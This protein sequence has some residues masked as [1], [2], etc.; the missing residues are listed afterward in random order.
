[1][2]SA[3]RLFLGSI[4]ATS[5]LLFACNTAGLKDSQDPAVPTGSSSGDPTP[6]EEGGASEDGGR[7]PPPELEG[8]ALPMS[9]NVSVQ[10]QPS[11]FGVAILNAIKGA[12]K[13][14]H[15]T[16]YLL[17]NDQ[18]INALGT[19]KNAGVD[20]KVVLNQSF[21][22]NAGNNQ[23]AYNALKAKGVNVRWAPS[24]Y[25]YTH[26]KTVII[27]GTSLLVM[28]M[29]LTE[30]S[31]K[32]NREF[33]ATDT[34]PQD[35]ADAE[36]IFDADYNDVTVVLNG[37]LVLSPQATSKLDARVRL[38]ALIDSAKKSVD[39]E[40]QS[41]SDKEITDSIV[42]AKKAGIACRVVL[43][44]DIGAPTPSEAEA[45][46]KLKGASI[47]V[48]DVQDPYIHAKAIVVDGNKAFVGSQ[49]FTPTALFN[50]REMGLITD[51]TATVSKLS[52]IIGQDFAA[53]TPR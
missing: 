5:A 50:N 1:M 32:D 43:A 13:S 52:Q 35:V 11:D 27:D 7:T 14:V 42:N 38:K 41:L 21:P 51:S 28:T 12:K 3:V 48:V 19:L 34:D 9:T 33:I 6:E 25:T 24:A 17:T 20:V 49:N 36:T 26:A 46:Q 23:P 15:M 22:P 44:T 31:A 10:V 37:K 47:P 4:L 8:G 39:V 53:G 30:T 2:R 29:N 45:L 16:M 40:V 18:I